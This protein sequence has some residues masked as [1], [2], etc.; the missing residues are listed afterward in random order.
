MK[1]LISI[2]LFLTMGVMLIGCAGMKAHQPSDSLTNEVGKS[3]FV[4]GVPFTVD[5]RFALITP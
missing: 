1:R 2:I 4:G 3:T 5:P